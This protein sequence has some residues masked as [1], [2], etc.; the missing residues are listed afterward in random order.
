MRMGDNVVVLGGDF[1]VGFLEFCLLAISSFA[2]GFACPGG[3]ETVVFVS[4]L[5]CEM[6][7]L[8]SF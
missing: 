5:N 2:L 1:I 7:R 6:A 3:N 4:I 8:R